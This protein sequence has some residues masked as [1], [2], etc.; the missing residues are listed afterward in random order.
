[1]CSLPLL[2]RPHTCRRNSPLGRLF[3]PVSHPG[4]TKWL[5]GLLKS[6]AKEHG[7]SG[8]LTDSESQE[9]A[10]LQAAA[11]E[12]LQALLSS[13]SGARVGAA[14]AGAAGP[15]DAPVRL[16]PVTGR[17]TG[18]RAPARGPSH[19]QERGR[20]LAHQLAGRDIS[21]KASQAP[22]TVVNYR[23]FPRGH[24]RQQHRLPRL[25][26]HQGLR[27]QVL[28][29]VGAVPEEQQTLSVTLAKP[30]DVPG[31]GKAMISWGWGCGV[32]H[33]RHL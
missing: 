9:I 18:L 5:L 14:G 17:S 32:V 27:E 30:L 33:Q 23:Y 28:S 2:P 10:E 12:T 1:M 15:A 7:R 25:Q 29:L 22:A 6:K 8:L 16:V 21:L 19:L 4:F 3:Q 31:P 24:G 11:L 13:S 20:A 26:E